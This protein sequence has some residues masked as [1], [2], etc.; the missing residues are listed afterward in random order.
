MT[1]VEFLAP[2]SKGKHQERVLAVLYYKERYENVGALTVDQIRQALRS[3]RISGHAKLNI[4]DVLGKAGHLVDT[5]GV[6]GKKRLW[7]LTESG[8]H[9]IRQLLQLPESDVEIEH[10]VGVL[11]NLLTK[12][13]DSDIKNYIEESLKCLQVGALRACI[14]FVWSGAIRT[15]QNKMLTVGG[16]TLN[17]AIT[18]HDPK[19]RKVSRIDDFAYIKDSVVLLAAKELAILDK[20]Q[21][22]TLEE[23]LNLRNRC[24]HP[25]KYRPGIKKASSFIEDIISIVFS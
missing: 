21:K 18:K 2:L 16:G 23:A 5:P 20:P 17:A 24:G 8:R 13:S 22:D 15:I 4:A 6:D 11:E 7:C 12:I 19:A 3:A 10:D 14:V 1:L 25:G 9:W